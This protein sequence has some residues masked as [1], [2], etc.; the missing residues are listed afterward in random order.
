MQHNTPS[1]RKLLNLVQR[2]LNEAPNIEVLRTKKNFTLPCIP[3]HTDLTATGQISSSP[4]QIG[5][6]RCLVYALL[7]VTRN[8]NCRSSSSRQSFLILFGWKPLIYTQKKRPLLKSK[9]HPTIPSSSAGSF[10][11]LKP[12]GVPVNTNWGVGA[13]ASTVKQM[14]ASIYIK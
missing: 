11:A 2:I 9:D 6:T 13:D 7:P 5:C 8:N 3:Q 1:L 4:M 14:K 10:S 12:T